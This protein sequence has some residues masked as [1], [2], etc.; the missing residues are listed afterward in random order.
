M[1]LKGDVYRTERARTSV[2]QGVSDQAE[3]RGRLDH[4]C[5]YWEQSYE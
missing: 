1:A 4:F 2:P 3:F 5:D